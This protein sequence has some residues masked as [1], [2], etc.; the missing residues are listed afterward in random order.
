MQH[1]AVVNDREVLR[2]LTDDAVAV[3]GVIIVVVPVG[4]RSSIE[5]KRVFDIFFILGPQ[6]I[7]PYKIVVVKTVVEASVAH[8]VL[9]RIIRA[10]ARKYLTAGVVE[11]YRCHVLDGSLVEHLH[12]FTV[13]IEALVS[14]LA[15]VYIRHCI[16]WYFL[17]LALIEEDIV[18]TKFC[19]C[20]STSQ[21]DDIASKSGCIGNEWL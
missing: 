9:I 6:C 5:S 13:F 8:Y 14:V 11:R 10:V 15:E 16:A 12:R 2:R 1:I 19:T 7:A 21:L 3:P 20:V 18:E 17:A 4:I